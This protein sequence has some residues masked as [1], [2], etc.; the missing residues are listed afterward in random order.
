LA[1]EQSDPPG[2]GR[3]GGDGRKNDPSASPDEPGHDDE[4]MLVFR[5]EGCLGPEDRATALGGGGAGPAVAG[6]GAAAVFERTSLLVVVVVFW[7]R[8]RN[9]QVPP[10]LPRGPSF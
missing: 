10:K 8:I 5:N 9:E 2:D 1:Q 6:T 4:L 3:G 7:R